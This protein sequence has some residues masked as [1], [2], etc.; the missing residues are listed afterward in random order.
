MSIKLS[1]VDQSPVY[2]SHPAKESPSLSATLAQACDQLGYYRYWVAEHH[3]SIHFANP[4][5]EILIAHIASITKNIRVGSGGVMLNHYSPYK[6]AECF[7][8]LATLFPDRIDLGIGRAPGGTQLTSQALSYFSRPHNG[9]LYATQAQDLKHFIDGSMPKDNAFHS[10]KV[11]PDNDPKP[12]MWMLG[13]SGGSAGLA[14]HLGYHIA[15]ARFID[16]DNCSPDIFKAH[17]NEWQKAKHAGTPNKMLAIACICAETNE[18]A[19]LIA[20]T[21]VYR[22]LAAQMGLREPFL[23][24]EQVQDRYNA[25]SHSYQSQ[26]DHILNGF[27][28]GT[29]TQCWDEINQLTKAYQCDEIGLVTV[30]HSFQDRLQSYQLLA[31]AL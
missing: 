28:V 15:L 22:K 29:A 17:L 9:E 10:L 31:E 27:T 16:P 13:S 11:L 2:G 14:G 1:V 5:P 20:G 26:Y 18:E 23:T 21:A 6:V 4:C 24:P 25:L 12:E 3:D 19:R 30:T 7:K 8:M